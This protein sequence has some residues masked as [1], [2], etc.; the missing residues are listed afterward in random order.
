MLLFDFRESEEK[1]F[2]D[3]K[4][5]N[6]DIKF[7][8][9]SLNE[10]TV[11]DIS[12]DDLDNAMIISVFSSSKI[13]ETV[14]SK[15]KNLR[16]ISTRSTG[17]DHICLNSCIRKNIALINVDSYGTKAVAQYTLGMI[18][19]LVRKLCP[20]IQA[21]I[22]PLIP[23]NFCGRDLD[24]MTLGIIGT[25]TVGASVCK[26]AN[27]IGMKILAYDTTPNKEMVEKYSV[28]YINQDDLLKNSDIVVLLIPYTKENYHMFSYDKFTMM[29]SGSYFINVSRGEFVDNE[30]L[31]EVAK[32]GKFK[33]IGLD[34]TACTNQKSA[35]NK[36]VTDINCIETSNALK[37]L[38]KLP[39]V[40]ITPQ[41]AYDTQ[42]SIDYILKSTFDGLNDF[43]QGGRKNR[44]Y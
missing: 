38:S 11:N 13:N 31:L 7:F 5:E 12:Q 25:G 27:A 36:D 26:Y 32:T 9:E 18:T 28:E 20:A 21:E 6:Y 41:I 34:V 22:N 4:L 1:F 8:K 29:K 15:F 3:N 44:I 42:E 24:T 14:L 10:I 23:N 19:A 43:L 2:K 37:E 33:G 35:D 39:N 16:I 17:Y 30:A 40:L